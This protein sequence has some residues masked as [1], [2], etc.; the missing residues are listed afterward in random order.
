MKNSIQ[1]RSDELRKPPN[2]LWLMSDQHHAGA[3]SCAGHPD[4]HT[5]HLDALAGEGTRFGAA[6]CNNPICGP[7]RATF[8]T[9]QHPHTHGVTGNAIFDYTKTQ[10]PNV[11]RYFREHGYQTALIG[12]AH[13]PKAW[14]KSG[15]GH[16]RYS[17]LTDAERSDPCTCHYFAHLLRHG[18]ADAYD[19]GKL[20]EGH[21]G[22][23]LRAF[24]SDIPL[25]H[26]LETW[27]GD[28]ACSFLDYRDH[29]RPF[30]LK[31]S[32]QRPHDPH[33]LSPESLGRIDP[34]SL[35]L[36]ENI[37]D[38]FE[39]KFADKPEFMREYVAASVE[40]YPYRPHDEADLRRQL[41]YYLTLVE[42]I[43]EQIG[44]I[45]A[46]LKKSGEWENTVVVYTADHGDF[47]GEH[48]LMLKN[49][50]IYEPIHRI[51]LIVRWPDAPTSVCD[52][53][54]ESVDFAPTLCA[55][56]GLPPMPD[57]EGRDVRPVA[58]GEESGLE[59][60]VCEWDFV[61]EGKAQFSL[62]AAAPTAWCFIPT[63]RTIANSTTFWRIPE[64]L[65]IYGTTKA[66]PS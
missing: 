60:V 34:E 31:V 42:L 25:A 66:K 65:K 40:G 21:P 13:L 12:K 2:V 59:H 50:G 57:T 37:A 33:A 64:K 63:R 7:S 56:V 29:S 39:R 53:I 16:I 41:A 44:R 4:V 27:T 19:H 26:S 11:A 9:G 48:G 46:R 10:P 23:N 30:F 49:L 1:Q 17:D 38:Y 18:L 52:A 6:Y 20:P 22:A 32:F 14:V 61:P 28:E 62:C 47:A 15:F 24:T 36:P 54:V 51:P 43:D 45:V 55:A 58:E 35:T 8:F 3:M 5:P